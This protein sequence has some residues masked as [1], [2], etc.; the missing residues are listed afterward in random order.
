MRHDLKKRKAYTRRK[1]RAKTPYY[2]ARRTEEIDAI[3]SEMLVVSRACKVPVMLMQK[4][5]E[6]GYSL[7]EIRAGAWRKIA[8]RMVYLPANLYDPRRMLAEERAI[9]RTGC[10]AAEVSSW[11]WDGHELTPPRARLENADGGPIVEKD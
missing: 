6:R 11:Q 4:M 5:L 7:S 2:S 9:I 1:H 10:T 8:G 3:E